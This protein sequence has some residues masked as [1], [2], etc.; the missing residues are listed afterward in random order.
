MLHEVVEAGVGVLHQ[1]HRVVAVVAAVVCCGGG[2]GLRLLGQADDVL[3]W[4]RCGGEEVADGG[5][6]CDLGAVVCDDVHSVGLRLED[7]WCWH[8]GRS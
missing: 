5:G 4:C 6:G 8:N 1:L 2:G 3:L 7:V